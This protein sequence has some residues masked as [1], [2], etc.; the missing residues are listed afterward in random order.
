MDSAPA[1]DTYYVSCG[2]CMSN[3][4]LYQ[5]VDVQ[6]R[7]RLRPAC[8]QANG[9]S[10]CNYFLTLREVE[11]ILNTRYEDEAPSAEDIVSLGLRQVIISR[12]L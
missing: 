2:H 9:E 8:P 10:G 11:E 5:S 3:D 12:H 6:L 7:E 4:V 1:S